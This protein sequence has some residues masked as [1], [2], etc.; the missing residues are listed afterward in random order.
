MA[1]FSAVSS[2]VCPYRRYVAHERI[3]RIRS[4]NSLPHY[5]HGI[6]VLAKT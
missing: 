1:L 6:L 4:K 3:S 2:E 5:F